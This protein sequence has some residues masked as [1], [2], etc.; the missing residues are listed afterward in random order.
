MLP[1][2]IRRPRQ[3]AVRRSRERGATMAL[4]ALAMVSIIAMAALS[5]DIGTLYEAKAEAQ[6]AADAAALTAARVISISGITGDPNNSASSWQPACGG[7]TSLATVAATSMA[8]QDLIGGAAPSTVTVNYGAGSAG[9]SNASCVGVAGFAVNPVVTVSVKRTN[10][11][12][13]FARVFSLFGSTYSGSSV[14]ATATAEVFNP[15]GSSPMI[16]VNPRCM[17]PWMVPNSDPHNGTCTGL[18]CP[19]FVNTASGAIVN[20]GTLA[21]NSGIIGE[22]FDLSAVCTNAHRHKCH[23]PLG[24]TGPVVISANTL[25]YA[26]GQTSN[27]S[28]AV[29]ANSSISGC[30]ATAVDANYWNAV[31]GCD[32]T[33]V[34]SC[35]SSLANTIDLSSDNP[36][37]P[38]NDSVSAAQCLINASASGLGNGQDVLIPATYPFQ[39]QAGANSALTVAGITSSSQITSSPSIVTLPIY[40]SIPLNPLST[41]PVTV[42][43]FLQVFINSA[44]TN[45]TTGTI[46]VTVMNVVGC[47]NGSSPG[48]PV[49][50]GTSPVPIRLIT[51]P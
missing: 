16:P 34:Y 36:G 39:I 1:P 10:L 42:L 45:G 17:K 41:T 7:S 4:V 9:G 51:A 12:V 44:T 13:F 11:P 46:N 26:P 50:L 49:A 8:Q 37:P 25:Q 27:A 20:P 18:A 38:G 47:G 43:G 6:R 32:Q 31:A 40:Q 15:S 23:L 35:G 19:N 29:A 30:S 33:T 5:I 2:L 3:R 22:T 48:P 14:S 28:V 21:G 24:S